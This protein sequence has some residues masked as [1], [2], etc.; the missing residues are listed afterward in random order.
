MAIPFDL[1]NLIKATPANKIVDENL[2][3]AR[4]TFGI[5]DEFLLKDYTDYYMDK[6]PSLDRNEG[7]VSLPVNTNVVNQGGDGGDEGLSIFDIKNKTSTG[8]KTPTNNNGITD[9]QKQLSEGV[10]YDNF[11]NS[12]KDDY[13]EFSKLSPDFVS[14]ED[15]YQQTAPFGKNPI[16]GEAYKQPRSISDQNR[17]LGYTFSDPNKFTGISSLRDFLPGGKYSLTGMAVRG[18]KGIN[19]AIQG[20]NFAKATSLADYRD[21]MSYGGYK[22]REAAR[23]KTMQEAR[24]LQKKIDAR[25]TSTPTN[26]DQGRGQPPP[27]PKTKTRDYGRDSTP[28]NPNSTKTASKSRGYSYSDS[29][30]GGRDRGGSRSSGRNSSQRGGGFNSFG[31]SDIRLKENVELIGKSPSNIN[32]YKFNYKDNPT[33][34]QGAMAHEVPWAS[35]KHSNGYMM[36][37][38]NQI[39]VEFKKI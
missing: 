17:I 22:E 38:Y 15:Y 31:F 35:V 36:V 11:M 30:G 1:A 21:M 25:K 10:G 23:E 19:N 39:D 32:I 29:P 12:I 4:K 24:D 33:T 28:N 18:L 14:F 2:L 34:Y 8:V 9:L 7:I 6:P 27:G 16:T 37:D 26:Q 20:T 3:N 5:D 13:N